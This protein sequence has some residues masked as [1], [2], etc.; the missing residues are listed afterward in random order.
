MGIAKGAVNSVVLCCLE[1]EEQDSWK[2]RRK[3]KITIQDFG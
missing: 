2:R 3:L 1:K